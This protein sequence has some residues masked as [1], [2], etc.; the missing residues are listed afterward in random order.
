M[1]STKLKQNLK[2][3]TKQNKTN[4]TK[5]NKTKQNKTKQNKTKQN[6][7]KQNKTKQ[8]KNKNKK[9]KKNEK[10][11]Q[12]Q[13]QQRCHSWIGSLFRNHIV[14]VVVVALGVGMIGQTISL[15]IEDLWTI[16][17]FFGILKY[18]QY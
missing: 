16:H 6:K 4:K 18:L 9:Q 1:I 14:V 13:Q 15:R 17:W 12:Q 7:T 3:K 10:R 11:K 8:N 2:Y 5:Q